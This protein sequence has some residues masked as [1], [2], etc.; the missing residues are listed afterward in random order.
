MSMQGPLLIAETPNAG[1]IG[2]RYL[3]PA[4]VPLASSQAASLVD[5]LGGEGRLVGPSYLAIR[6]RAVQDYSDRIGWETLQVAGVNTSQLSEDQRQAIFGRLEHWL[7]KLVPVAQ[8]VDWSRHRQLVV[9]ND[10]LSRWQKEDFDSLPAADLFPPEPVA[11][12][13]PKKDGTGPSHSRGFVAKAGTFALLLSLVGVSAYL[14][15]PG[16]EPGPE[17]EPEQE[18][19]PSN[20][21][22]SSKKGTDE[23]PNGKPN[24]RPV[25]KTMEQIQELVKAAEN[26]R[27]TALAS[28]DI[29]KTRG[30]L[31][32]LQSCYTDLDDRSRKLDYAEQSKLREANH[33][34]EAVIQTW[35]SAVNKRKTSFENRTKELTKKTNSLDRSSHNNDNAE[36][37]LS[38]LDA[39]DAELV[40][41]KVFRFMPLDVSKDAKVDDFQKTQR[42]RWEELRGQVAVRKREWA[43]DIKKSEIDIRLDNFNFI[44]A[45]SLAENLDSPDHTEA[46]DLKKKVIDKFKEYIKKQQNV[47]KNAG[48]SV[49]E[50]EN[51]INHLEETRS[52]NFLPLLPK[53]SQMQDAIAIDSLRNRAIDQLKDELDRKRYDKLLKYEKMLEAGQAADK[54]NKNALANEYLDAKD[55]PRRMYDKVKA[56]SHGSKE[57]TTLTV[58]K[59]INGARIKGKNVTLSFRSSSDPNNQ[60]EIGE[61]LTFSIPKQGDQISERAIAFLEGQPANI[62]IKI[63]IDEITTAETIRIQTNEPQS[64]YVNKNQPKPSAYFEI[65]FSHIAGSTLPRYDPALPAYKESHKPPPPPAE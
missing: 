41:D 31:D 39:I 53:A 9:G 32:K 27:D 24:P 4:G 6:R 65:K 12:V 28:A 62:Y 48:A 52:V 64:L 55:T 15:W 45:V 11:I 26:L 36:E 51:A 37:L 63:T 30:E 17:P 57:K 1:E 5:R 19:A 56:W 58:L 60:A 38:D 18:A 33:A 25:S 16:P 43:F 21:E 61:P 13:D 34:I 29:A 20:P 54:G 40:R 14:L 8:A 10:D 7:E 3:V 35:V 23:F 46:D 2:H 44:D 59:I 22:P 47:T 50:I 42:K 49:M